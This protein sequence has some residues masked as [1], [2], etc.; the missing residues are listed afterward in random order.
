MNG[1]GMRYTE[2]RDLIHHELRRKAGGLTW[3]ELREKLGL[4]YERACPEWT[5]RLEGEIGLRRVKG[6]GRALVWRVAGWDGN[7]LD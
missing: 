2:Y 4:P 7:G 3:A 6:G 5:K 1:T